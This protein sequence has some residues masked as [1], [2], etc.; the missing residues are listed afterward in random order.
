ML[1]YS[2]DATMF[3]MNNFNNYGGGRTV[4][5]DFIEALYAKYNALYGANVPVLS[6]RTQEIGQAMRARMAYNA[7]GVSGQLA[8]GDQITL[9]TNQAATI[10]VTG[11]S[12]GANVESYAGQ[13]ISSIAMGSNA[14][15]V[16]P[17][18]AA[19]T[20]AAIGGLTAALSG[21]NVVLNWP[22]VTQATDGSALSA[23]VYRVYVRANDPAF[24]PTPADLVAEV[25]GTTF[26]HSGGLGDVAQ[27]YTYVVTAI[28]NNCWK[29]ESTPSKRV[30]RFG[31][32]MAPGL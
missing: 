12:F 31:F 23:L 2:V 19:K 17:G 24:T 10:P 28:G 16:I 21:N 4:M 32:T 7:S 9:R 6:L 26:T 22:A 3:H 8:C 18:A 25:A 1:D 30:G 29:L 11:V 5:T 20:P 27:N 15:V 13:P 14:T